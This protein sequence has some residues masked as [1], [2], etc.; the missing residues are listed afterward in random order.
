MSTVE[1]IEFNYNLD[2]KE[3]IKNKYGDIIIQIFNNEDVKIEN[4]PEIQIIKAQYYIANKAPFNAEQ[5]LLKLAEQN[6]LDGIYNLALYYYIENDHDQSMTCLIRGAEANHLKSIVNL[7]YMYYL[8]KDYDNFIKYNNIGIENNEPMAFIYI[9]LYNWYVLNNESEAFRYLNIH[10]NCH[11][12]FTTALLLNEKNS[13]KNREMIIFNCIKALQLKINKTYINLLNEH[14]TTLHRYI[15]YIDN[16][17][18]TKFIPNEIIL[19][20]NYCPICLE[21]NKLIKL[22]CKHSICIKCVKKNLINCLV[23]NEFI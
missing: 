13:L 1:E 22:I 7:S 21:Y 14:T 19:I 10:L 12:F 15:L 5:I 4:D 23:C 16:N 20:D 18:N 11:S 9:A 6:H 8:D 17:I 3:E 2:Y